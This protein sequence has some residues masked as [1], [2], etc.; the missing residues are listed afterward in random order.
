MYSGLLEYF[1]KTWATIVGRLGEQDFFREILDLKIPFQLE[2]YVANS[3][4]IDP[5]N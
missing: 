4:N 2:V 5:K 3:I 1:T